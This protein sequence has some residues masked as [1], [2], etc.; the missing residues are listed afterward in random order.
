[1]SSPISVPTRSTGPATEPPAVERVPWSTLGPQF[2]AK[3]GYPR[4]KRMPEH[5]EI[6]GQ[7]GSGKSHFEAMILLQRMLGRNSH[8]V[9][10]A[11]KPDDS[12]LADLGLPV[13]D[14][15]P[16]DDPR[17]TAVI[18]WPQAAGLN[19]AGQQEQAAKI[20][21][22][23]EQLWHPNANIIIV[24]DEIAYLCTDLHQ[25]DPRLGIKTALMKYYREGRALHITIVASTQRPQGVIR[26]MHSESSWTICFAPKDEEDAE[27]MAQVLGG[28]RTY[29][30]ILNSLDREKFEF[31]IVHGLTGKMYI[32][33][34]DHPF[35]E[36]PKEK[37]Q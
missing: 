6:L 5:V 37:R 23:L 14:K 20:M 25:A 4:G 27:R 11:T 31:L 3:W 26:Q 7:S 34:I 33:W 29:M 10:V 2:L 30:P 1:M 17:H 35:P 9:I 18:Y 24:F 16:P 36:V 12:T 15:Y 32:S 19:K 28:K 8:I 22:L 13:V 21:K